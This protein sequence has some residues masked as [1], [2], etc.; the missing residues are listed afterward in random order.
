MTA[1]LTRE[2]KTF[3][4]EFKA[5]D[6]AAGTFEAIVSVFGTKDLGGDIV[7]PGAFADTLNLW[8][9]KGDPIPIIWSHEWDDPH[10]HIGYVVEALETEKGLWIKGQLDVERPFAEQVHHLLKNRRVTQ[11]SFGYFAED[12][13]WV[14][15]PDTGRMSRELHRVTVFEVGPTLLGMNPDTELISAASATHGGT[16]GAAA[17]DPDPD[18]KDDSG[19][20]G[21]SGPT[22]NTVNV[23]RAQALLVRPMHEGISNE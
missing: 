20:A 22:V 3:D 15:D 5:V 7:M 11:F 10:A 19:A 9:A 1:L 12:V 8:A 18:Q 14:E 13:K 2:T 16:G 23:E 4:A 21:D 6:T 17:G